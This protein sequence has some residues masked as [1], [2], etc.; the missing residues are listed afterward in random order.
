MQLIDKIR[1]LNE[2]HAF[3]IAALGGDLNNLSRLGTFHT[4]CLIKTLIIVLPKIIFTRCFIA[5]ITKATLITETCLN[6]SRMRKC[7][8]LVLNQTLI[9]EP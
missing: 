3:D 4:T 7:N 2:L 8:L 6:I 5:V 1:N 9:L